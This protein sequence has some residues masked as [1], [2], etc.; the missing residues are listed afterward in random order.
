MG[1]ALATRIRA[2]L[3]CPQVYSA[4]GLPPPALEV[5]Y[6]LQQWPGVVGRS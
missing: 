1:F 2:A 4:V 6:P 5:R 3:Q